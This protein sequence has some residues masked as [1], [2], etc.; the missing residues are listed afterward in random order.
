VT[1][2]KL[3]WKSHIGNVLKKLSSAC[4]AITNVTPLLVEETL[5][6][7]YFAYAHS[8]LSYGIILR[9]NSPHSLSVFKMQKRI[10]CIMTKVRHIDSCTQFKKKLENLTILFSIYIFF[11]DV[12]G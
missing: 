9:G 6:T 11:D 2:D 4:Y 3:S 1:I 8:I 10:L 12:C 5:R 7:I